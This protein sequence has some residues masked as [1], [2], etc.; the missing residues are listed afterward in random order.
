M[1]ATAFEDLIASGAATVEGD[2]SILATLAGLMVQFDPLF[3]VMPGT[4]AVPSA[5]DT[6]SSDSLDVVFG[7]IPPE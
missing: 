5:I 6:V 4:A 7:A 1:G 2:V 3:E